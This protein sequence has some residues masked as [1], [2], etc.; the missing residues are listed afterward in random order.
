MLAGSLLVI[1]GFLIAFPDWRTTII[2]A[3]LTVAT[4]VLALILRKVVGTKPTYSS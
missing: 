4:V 1:G 2:G 3:I